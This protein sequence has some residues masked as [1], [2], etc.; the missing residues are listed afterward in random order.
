MR[1][2]VFIILIYQFLTGIIG[3]SLNSDVTRNIENPFF[4]YSED[5]TELE[6]EGTVLFDYE[7]VELNNVFY[8]AVVSV[9]HSGNGDLQFFQVSKFGVDEMAFSLPNIVDVYHEESEETAVEYGLSSGYGCGVKGS[10]VYPQN[11]LNAEYID[12]NGDGKTEIVLTGIQ[13]L[14]ISEDGSADYVAKTFVV[15][16]VYR[17]DEKTDSLAEISNELQEIVPLKK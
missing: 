8:V 9:S 17:Y 11:K 7:L 15:E 1:K 5:V 10:L 14:I 6:F 12:T 3:C 13:Q 2:N 16:R 4:P